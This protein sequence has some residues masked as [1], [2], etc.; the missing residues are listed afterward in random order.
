MAYDD[1][2]GSGHG[3]DSMGAISYANA[4]QALRG[5]LSYQAQT[6]SPAALGRMDPGTA[7]GLSQAGLHEASALAAA[8]KVELAR[9]DDIMYGIDS[10]AVNIAAAATATLTVTPQKRHIPQRIVLSAATAA[11]FVVND[12]RVGVEPVLATTGAISAAVFIQDASQTPPFRAVVCEVGMTVSIQVTNIS[13]AA[14][15]F[16]CTVIGKYLPWFLGA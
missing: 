2:Y 8:A 5:R 4:L 1:L 12:L 9:G 15:R 13:G 10:A 11:N 7:A 6:L 3:Y 16:T 14:A